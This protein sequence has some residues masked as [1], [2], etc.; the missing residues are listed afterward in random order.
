MNGKL[1][2]RQEEILE[3]ALNLLAQ[4]GSY[5]L[6]LRNLAKTLDITEPALYRHFESKKDLLLALYGFTWQKM[7]SRL[8]PLTE[9]E[10][11]PIEKLNAFLH[12]FFGYLTENRGVNLVLLSEAIHH[13][14]PDLKRAMFTLISNFQNL[15]KKILHQ[16]VV[17]GKLREDLE[18][19]IA[20]RLVLGFFQSTV[21][22]SLLSEEPLEAS[23]V[24]GPFLKIFLEGA[25]R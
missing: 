16:G 10:I 6:T 9:K 12:A 25:K 3:A 24:I 21:T 18:P 7:E 20:S 4:G 17:E 2:K 14:D 15:I 8:L 19:K 11:D 23:K 5:A 22:I 13:N 1:K